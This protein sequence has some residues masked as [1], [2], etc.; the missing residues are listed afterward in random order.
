[1]FKSPVL[2]DIRG[3]IWLKA[4][5]TLAFNPI[6][7]LTHAY[8]GDLCRL[9][10]TRALALEMMREGERV[11]ARLGAT[12][13]LPIERRLARAE[14]VGAHKTSMLQDI[15]AGRALEIEAI[16]SAERQLGQLTG[17]PTPYINAIYACAKLLDQTLTSAGGRL[18]IDP[19]SVADSVA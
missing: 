11:A 18:R 10:E 1:G 16:L 7:A 15:E 13:R 8:L 6:S 9:P 17:T 12:I 3:E 2:S 19:I 5:G 4:V 14:A